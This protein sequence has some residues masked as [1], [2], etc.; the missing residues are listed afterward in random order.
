MRTVPVW[1]VTLGSGGFMLS[2]ARSFY[3]EEHNRNSRNKKKLNHV[4][5]RM[6]CQKKSLQT[7]GRNLLLRNFSLTLPNMELNTVV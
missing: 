6:V 7:M 2:L 3:N 5:L 4:L 1:R